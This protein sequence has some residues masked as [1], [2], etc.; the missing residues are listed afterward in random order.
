M[1]LTRRCFS[2]ENYPLSVSVETPQEPELRVRNLGQDSFQSR[3]CIQEDQS[4]ADLGLLT[5]DQ[6]PSGPHMVSR[7]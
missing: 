3:K 1:T 6:R 2:L 7:R 5:S 4:D